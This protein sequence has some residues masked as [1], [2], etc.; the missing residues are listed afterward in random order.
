MTNGKDVSGKGKW[1]EELLAI[2]FFA[3]FFFG[4]I[5][6]YVVDAYWMN[7]TTEQVFI[8]DDTPTNPLIALEYDDTG[9]VNDWDGN[10]TT[11][12]LADWGGGFEWNDRVPIYSY[13]RSTWLTVWNDTGI[14]NIGVEDYQV[15]RMKIDN[16]DSFLLNELTY[17]IDVGTGQD[18]E[19][20]LS[21][22]VWQND[23]EI[24]FG[25]D[26]AD[27][28]R[29]AKYDVVNLASQTGWVNDTVP[30]SL[31][32]ALNIYQLANT[33]RAEVYLSIYM[34]DETKNGWGF[35]FTEH[36]VTINGTYQRRMGTK[37]LVTWTLGVSATLNVVVGLIAMDTIDL[38]AIGEKARDIGKK[39]K[40][41]GGG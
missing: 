35:H 29:L 17:T 9:S 21:I 7:T 36:H 6:V 10:F 38:D 5:G 24:D 37:S 25:A 1:T 31:L 22:E 39:Y 27:N 33:D 30:I 20:V 28:D 18:K 41:R 8:T 16:A 13:N 40:K 34:T 19:L 26:N 12:F 3:V 15:I 14:L 2:I 4:F 11:G 23:G 32:N